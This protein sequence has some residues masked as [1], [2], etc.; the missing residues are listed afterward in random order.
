MKRYIWGLCYLFLSIISALTLVKGEGFLFHDCYHV[1]GAFMGIGAYLL[2]LSLFVSAILLFMKRKGKVVLRIF[3]LV[4]IPFL[5]GAMFHIIQDKN[6]YMLTIESLSEL[7]R[8]GREMVSGGLIAGTIAIFIRE[9]FTTFGGF[10]ILLILLIAAL[11]CAFRVTPKAVY[12]ALVPKL[13]EEYDEEEDQEPEVTLP[14]FR[15]FSKNKKPQIDIPIDDAGPPPPVQEENLLRA[16]KVKSPAQ[17]LREKELEVKTPEPM[18]QTLEPVAQHIEHDD[19]IK[20]EIEK[21]LQTPKR[22]AGDLSAAQK[23]LYG[24]PPLSLLYSSKASKQNSQAEIRENADRLIDT[25]LSFGIEANIINITRG[26]TVT[27]YEIQ[28]N[29]G[30]KFS[31]ITTLSDDIALSL[32]AVSVRIAPIPDKMAVGIEV[33]NQSVQTVYIHDV[34]ASD[35]FT[36]SRSKIAFAVGRDITG[37]CIVGDIAKM[38]HMLIAGT[39]GSGKSVCINSMLISLLY[40]A[41]PEEVKLIMIDPKMIELGIYNGIPHLLIPVVTDPKKAAGALNWAVTEMMHRY[42]LFSELNVRDLAS[43]NEAVIK[44]PAQDDGSEAKE[45]L[46]QI[47]IVID[48]LADLMFVAARDVENAICRIAQMARAAGMHLVIA[49]QRP[50]ADVIT[51]IMKAN[52]PS[53]IAF[54]VASQIESRIILDS[55]GAE[56]LIGRGDMLYNPLGAGKPLRVQ[57]CFI[58]SQEIE[59][60]I[61]Y[62]KKTGQ[63]DYSEEILQHIERE[64]GEG[65]GDVSAESNDLDADGLLPNAIEI[66]VETGQASVSMLQ[67]RLK[68]GYSRAAR[69][70][71]QMEERG[72]VGPFEGSKPRQVLITKDEWQEMVLRKSQ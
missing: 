52:I 2:P 56:K 47:V 26:P 33:P 12:N 19:S 14:E 64:A 44:Q 29:R 35:A 8:G 38:P 59:S 57:G 15:I 53:R 42:K 11:L 65:G 16:S 49:T 5:F 37:T 22:E 46:P 30:T 63:P 25:L 6:Q 62:I 68:L 71:D 3:S 7:I 39:T 45:P 32:G 50:S 13:Y 40:K 72:I 51:G 60:V 43:Y 27:R 18:V 54:A 31:R 66:V 36:K 24:Y 21:A 41:S 70:V 61:E 23:K 67:R 17:V 28:V 9:L 4:S 10:C 69:L 55:M 48:E 58:T 20:E 34:I 1:A